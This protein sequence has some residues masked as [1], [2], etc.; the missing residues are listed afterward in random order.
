M[1]LAKK[2]CKWLS[3]CRVEEGDI[4]ALKKHGDRINGKAVQE[5]DAC[6]DKNLTV[7]IIKFSDLEEGT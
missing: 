1:R 4:S 3:I 5:I 7:K 6:E 2:H